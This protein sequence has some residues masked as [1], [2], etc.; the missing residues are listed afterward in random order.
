M[1]PFGSPGAKKL[2]SF[3]VS[4]H[5]DEGLAAIESFEEKNPA[6]AIS[7]LVVSHVCRTVRSFVFVHFAHPVSEK[8][9]R[10]L[11]VTKAKPQI[12]LA[13][14][15]ACPR[16]RTVPRALARICNLPPSSIF[17]RNYDKR[18][19]GNPGRN[20]QRA[21]RLT[22]T[23]IRQISSMECKYWPHLL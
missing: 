14:L 10:R 23:R 2:R 20:A 9:L 3:G 19:L 7:P 5:R 11:F 18:L 17:K 12:T 21:A 16:R 1:A 13:A 4:I 6:S 15:P 8:T 22:A